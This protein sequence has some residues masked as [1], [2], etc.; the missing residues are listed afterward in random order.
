[1]IAA[2]ALDA[3]LAHLAASGRITTYGALALDL[4]LDGAGRIARLTS[5]LEQT[6][7]LDARAG[8]PL[9]AAR[10]VGRTSGGLPARGFFAKARALG[11]YGGPDDGPLA[12]A[13]H[14]RQ[15]SP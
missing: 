5:A 8:T 7:E 4:G 14:A 9:R 13:F 1:M 11:L 2:P 10:V 12:Q 15:L 6:M 3:A